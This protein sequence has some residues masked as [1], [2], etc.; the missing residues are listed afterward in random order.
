MEVSNGIFGWHKLH[1]QGL[2]TL[3]KIVQDPLAVAL[4]PRSR[5]G[6]TPSPQ[7][8]AACEDSNFI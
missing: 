7:Q 1:P 8:P 5:R 4:T 3:S 2:G 6:P